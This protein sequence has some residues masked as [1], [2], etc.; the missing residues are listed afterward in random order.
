M[1]CAASIS[2]IAN[3]KAATAPNSARHKASDARLIDW[4]RVWCAIF[5]LFSRDGLCPL[6]W[7][8]CIPM[9]LVR[10]ASPSAKC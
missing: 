5:V 1:L 4:A 9:Q 6:P 2:I 10:L 3:L 7:L 8:A